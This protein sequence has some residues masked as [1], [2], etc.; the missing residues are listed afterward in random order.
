MKFTNAIFMPLILGAQ[1]AS[2]RL[3][4]ARP[5]DQQR[6]LEVTQTTI[7]NIKIA[8]M[9]NATSDCLDSESLCNLYLELAIGGI[10]TDNNNTNAVL[11]A[12]AAA[13]V[14]C[15][16]AKL[17]IASANSRF[18]G[19]VQFS[20]TKTDGDVTNIELSS[21]L[22]HVTQAIA[23]ASTYTG[24]ATASG[25][26][27]F[28]YMDQTEF[29]NS[30]NQNPA[31]TAEMALF[32][33]TCADNDEPQ[34]SSVG[35]AAAFGIAYAQ[36]MGTSVSEAFSAGHTGTR[37]EVKGEDIQSFKAS[38]ITGASSFAGA[39]SVSL[40][41]S[42]AASFAE[43]AVATE[44]FQEICQEWYVGYCAVGVDTELAILICD[45]DVE[46]M[47]SYVHELVIASADSFAEAY[48]EAATLAMVRSELTLGFEVN[49]MKGDNN[50]MV[51]DVFAEDVVPVG[52]ISTCNM[53][54]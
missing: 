51:L 21:D 40:S 22:T 46:E 48:A 41:D 50:D 14:M 36:S 39:G 17:A 32:N 47:C 42:F 20:V 13:A 45:S 29:C 19:E 8:G 11:Y 10:A 25:S 33:Y 34:T 24:S 49:F 44:S 3:R 12:E 5:A 37:I 28:A 9:N 54:Y 31:G 26:V 6:N 52:V 18:D 4:G 15:T 16:S 27:A 2:A 38:V 1:L 53:Q 30:L 35:D 43:T 23:V 7:Q